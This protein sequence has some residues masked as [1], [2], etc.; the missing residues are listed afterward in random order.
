M[1]VIIHCGI[2]LPKAS[3]RKTPP[4]KAFAI[5]I[6]LFDSTKLRIFMGTSQQTTLMV[7]KHIWRR[8][9]IIL[10]LVFS[11]APATADAVKGEG[12]RRQ[13]KGCN[14]KLALNK[15]LRGG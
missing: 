9:L 8:I 6:A 13:F 4:L 12:R 2:C 7:V 11:N 15:V 3:E 1:Q 10:R 14:Y 5:L